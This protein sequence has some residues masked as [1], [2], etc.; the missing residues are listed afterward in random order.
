MTNFERIKAMSPDALAHFLNEAANGEP[1]FEWMDKNFCDFCDAVEKDG[2]EL[3]F[4]EINHKCR[5]GFTIDDIENIIYRWLN[6]NYKGE[7][8]NENY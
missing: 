3:A 4:C 1:W 2:H 5:Y 8:I 7:I 6:E